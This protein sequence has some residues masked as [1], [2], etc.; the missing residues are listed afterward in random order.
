MIY[1]YVRV[2]MEKQSVSSV[3]YNGSGT[4]LVMYICLSESD[5]CACKMVLSVALTEHEARADA[6]R[7]IQLCRTPSF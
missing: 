6:T 5:D 4:L 2:S 1:A 3:E 7:E